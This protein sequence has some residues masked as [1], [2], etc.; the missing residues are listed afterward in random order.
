MKHSD[1]YP[2]G[3][4]EDAQNLPPQ[5]KVWGLHPLVWAMIV[6]VVLAAVGLYAEIIGFY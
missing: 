4:V 6:V 2:P 3:T 5:I 1:K